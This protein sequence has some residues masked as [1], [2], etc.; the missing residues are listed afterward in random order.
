MRPT[1]V[2]R[3]PRGVIPWSDDRPRAGVYGDPVTAARLPH[4]P[5]RLGPRGE[6]W[7]DALLAGFLVLPGIAFVVGGATAIGVFSL[8]G[9]V[10]LFWRRRAPVL[11]LAAI[12]LGCAAQLVAIDVPVWGQIGFLIAVYTVARRCHAAWGAVAVAVGLV[13]AVLGPV[14]WLTAVGGSLTA[15]WTTV[16]FTATTVVAAWALGALGRTRE[17]YVDALIERS[18]QVERD[19]E[20]RVV[21]AAQDERAR[22]AREMHDVVAHGLTTMVVLA[23]G[24]RY[25]AAADPAAGE[26]ALGTISETGREA[27]TEMRGLLGLLRAGETGVTPLPT[28]GDLARLIEADGTGRVD[29]T[30]PPPGTEVP[31]GVGLTAYRI[32][33]E[34]LTNVRKHAGP[35]PQVTVR[36]AVDAH[37]ALEIDVHDDGRGASGDPAGEGGAD[38]GLGIAGMRERVAAHGGTFRAGPAPGG[39][40]GVSAR[41]PL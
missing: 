18:E 13:G 40:F 29:A 34:A 37:T 27:L 25:A 32:V 4:Q 31:A 26:R 16:A 17:A 38:H 19:A 5:W 10:P 39:G 33:Q 35:D 2:V 20:Q 30:L 3:R 8:A 24:A 28:L 15:S 36:V 6:R 11:V 41:I 1:A 14:D 12:S 9:T 23:D 7:F 21:L 22:I